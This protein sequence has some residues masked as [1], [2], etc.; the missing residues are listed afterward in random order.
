MPRKS[1]LN[2]LS[3][4]SPVIVVDEEGRNIPATVLRHG[5]DVA[6]IYTEVVYETGE[7]ER[8][9]LLD[10]ERPATLHTDGWGGRQRQHCLVVGET[11]KRYRVR[12][13]PGSELRLPRGSGVLKV[14]SSGTYLVPKT[15][16]TFER[17]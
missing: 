17:A 12:A 13:L 10:Q 16:V 4:G 6:G 3:I 8:A 9:A 1:D 5:R 15:A 14:L 11:A 2:R 7:T